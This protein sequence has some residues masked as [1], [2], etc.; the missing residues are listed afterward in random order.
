MNN[1]NNPISW[2]NADGSWSHYCVPEQDIITNLQSEPCN[3]C[4]TPEPEQI[5]KN[6]AFGVTHAG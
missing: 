4:D 1:T 2:R 6:T 3:W 5:Y